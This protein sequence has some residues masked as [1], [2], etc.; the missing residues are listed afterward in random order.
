MN[1]KTLYYEIAVSCA[2]VVILFAFM[3]GAL[4]G[5]DRGIY[6]NRVEAVE[7]GHATWEIDSKGVTKFHWKP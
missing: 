2:S 3:A 4:I 7:H 6:V 5:K 1:E